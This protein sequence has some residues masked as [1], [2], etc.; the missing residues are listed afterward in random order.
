M[1]KYLDRESWPQHPILARLVF[2]SDFDTDGT[3]QLIDYKPDEFEN[4]KSIKIEGSKDS[5][6]TWE[7]CEFSYEITYVSGVGAGWRWPFPFESPFDR[8]KELIWR[9]A[10]IE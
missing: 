10:F 6:V 7:D 1:T 3:F 2:R 4:L 5:G 9:A 8:R